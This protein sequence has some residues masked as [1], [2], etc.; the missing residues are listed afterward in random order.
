[1]AS[2]LQDANAQAQGAL[3]IAIKAVRPD[4]EPQSE[5]WQQYPEMEWQDGA[6]KDYLVPW[7][8]VT[9]ENADQ[10][11]EARSKL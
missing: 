10:L 5:I 8:P 9:T 6:A 11:L 1:M 3:D 4:Y 2:I 7:T